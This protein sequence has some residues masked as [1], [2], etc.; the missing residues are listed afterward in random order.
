MQTKHNAIGRAVTRSVVSDLP[1]VS[2]EDTSGSKGLSPFPE[3]N[4]VRKEMRIPPLRSAV[5]DGI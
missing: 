3:Y 2:Q 5:N 4:Q 1:W